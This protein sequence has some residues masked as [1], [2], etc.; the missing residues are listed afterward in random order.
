MKP[1]IIAT[2]LAIC[3]NEQEAEIDRLSSIFKKFGTIQQ[4]RVVRPDRKLPTYLQV[5]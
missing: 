2:V 5:R 1:R 4:M 3:V